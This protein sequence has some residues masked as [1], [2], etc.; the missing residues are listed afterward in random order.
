MFED[1]EHSS[2]YFD[3]DKAVATQRIEMSRNTTKYYAKI[4]K[5]KLK[6]KKGFISTVASFYNETSKRE[7]MM[8]YEIYEIKF[9]LN[10]IFVFIGI[11][12]IIIAIIIIAIFCVVQKKKNKMTPE[13]LLFQKNINTESMLGPVR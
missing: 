4:E 1:E 13:E 6:N 2:I 7:M 9:G 3:Y 8:A 5:I 11:G 12:L 10:W